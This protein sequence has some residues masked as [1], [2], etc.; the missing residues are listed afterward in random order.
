ML[1]SLPSDNPDRPR[2][3]KGYKLMM[4]SLLKFQ[5]ESGMWHQL[6]DD[7]QS[8]PETSCSGMFAFAFITGVTNGWLD[9][10]TY[11]PAARKAWLG[12]TTYLEPNGDIR[13]VCQGTNK[14]NDREV[15]R[16]IVTVMEETGNN[17]VKKGWFSNWYATL[18]Q[19]L[20]M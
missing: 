12:L 1:R 8:W 14:K 9:E 10:K 20:G 17:K 13:E 11:G 4:E 2:I 15:K 5:D 19:D 16:M 3:E 18:K 6:I 7:P